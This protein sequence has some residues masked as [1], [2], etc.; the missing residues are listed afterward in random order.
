MMLE[1]L[2]EEDA[3]KA[4]ENAVIKI[5]RTKL[6]SLAAGKMGYSTSQVGDLVVENL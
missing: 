5:V 4:I 3:A 6:K 1:T 2:G